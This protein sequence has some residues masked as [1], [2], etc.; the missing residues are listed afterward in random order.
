MDNLTIYNNIE[1]DKNQISNNITDLSPT[2]E[3]FIAANSI[4]GIIDTFGDYIN[5]F[6][7]YRKVK[8][9]IKLSQDYFKKAMIHIQN[10]NYERAY[11]YYMNAIMLNPDDAK[12]HNSFAWSLAK[13]NRDLE[14]A[15]FHANCAI[16]IAI[17]NTSYY[18]T[19]AEVLFR[20]D[21]IDESYDLSLEAFKLSGLNGNTLFHSQR[22]IGFILYRN[23]EYNEANQWLKNAMNYQK[24]EN[25]LSYIAWTLEVLSDT[26]RRCE[27][28]QNQI[29]CLHRVLKMFPNTISALNS[30][31]WTLSLHFDN[32]S[33]EAT[34]YALKAI[35]QDPD[36]PSLYDTL[37][38]AYYS[39]NDFTKAKEV[40]RKALDLSNHNKKYKFL[41]DFRIGRIYYN[42]GNYL[43]AIEVFKRCITYNCYD[44]DFDESYV[45]AYMACSYRELNDPEMACFYIKKASALNEKW[46]NLSNQFHN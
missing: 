42:L 41:Y 4:F 27:L 17:D 24:Y 33:H 20:M 38:E 1:G 30:M 3:F 46:Q 25:D 40:S 45:Y 21:R 31:A 14:V 43:K 16:K 13:R 35:G 19:K 28:Y 34:E 36:N 44:D 5:K 7:Q 9:D 8:C 37:A 12:I 15:L 22:R 18:D 23:E 26:Y 6:K 32:S 11:T 2:T 10:N 29:D 39:R